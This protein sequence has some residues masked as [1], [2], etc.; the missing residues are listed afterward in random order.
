METAYKTPDGQCF[1]NKEET[2]RH[3]AKIKAIQELE[4]IIA[5]IIFPNITAK[6]LAE[7]LYYHLEQKQ[8]EI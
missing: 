3:I 7:D 6:E 5:G 4:E 2:Q 8:E 1:E